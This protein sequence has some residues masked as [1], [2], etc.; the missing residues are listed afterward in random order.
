MNRVSTDLGWGFVMNAYPRGGLEMGWILFLNWVAVND[1]SRN[2]IGVLYRSSFLLLGLLL[3]GV[4]FSACDRTPEKG[5][6]PKPRPYVK[7]G[8]LGADNLAY[9]WAKVALTATANDTERFRPRPTVSSR[10]LA[11]VFTSMYDAWSHYDSL[12]EACI[13]RGLPRRPAAEHTLRNKEIAIS[14][15]AYGALDHYFYSDSA[16]FRGFM[17]ELGL[18]PKDTTTDVS[19]PQGMGNFIA[20]MVIASRYDDGANEY[21]ELTGSDGRSYSDYTGYQPINS[22]DE[23]SDLIHWQPKYFA[24]GKGGRFA[25]AC[26]TPHWGRVEPLLIDSAS[27]F[28]AEPPPALDS[29]QLKK[30]VQEVIDLSANLT[31][32]EK[33]LV[34]FMRD[35]PKSV[36]QAGHWLMFAQHVSLRDSHDLNQDI[37]MYFLVTAVA[38]DAFIACWETKLHYDYTR[39]Y[40][41]VHDFYKDKEITA[42][43]GPFKGP[44]K[45][46]GQDW[47]PY[48]PETFV[49]PPFPGYVS[50]HSTVSGACAEVLKRFTGSD[51][52]GLEVRRLPGA[53]TELGIT[54]DSVALRFPTF[55]NTAEQAGQSRVLGGYH[56]QAD[57]VA[58]LKLGRDVAARAWE[59]YLDLIKG[60]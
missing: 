32:E 24:D 56:I 40:A 5:K 44:V 33:A 48:S 34:E 13:V 22:V 28:R 3:G 30:E 52:F 6:Y 7:E 54:Q 53:L 18:N 23:N 60:R 16:M 17:L 2:M 38:M 39:P 8:A 21:G 20:Q 25:P 59:E 10:M 46:K 31:L 36:Q 51:D 35:G 43:G 58:G 9:R 1:F 50:G 49:C 15:A 4:F 41:L 19:K 11:L 27:Q 55:S 37:K 29:D 12:A 45:M 47:I 42:W 14:H 26:L 57:N